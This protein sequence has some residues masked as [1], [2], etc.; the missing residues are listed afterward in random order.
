MLRSR[1]MAILRSE[2][3]LPF[4]TNLPKDVSIN[5]LHWSVDGDADNDANW[6]AIANLVQAFWNDEVGGVA[7][8]E[9][10]SSIIKRDTDACFIKFYD[11]EADPQVLL[12]QR[13]F[14]LAAT[15]VA[16]TNYPNEVAICLSLTCT[17]ATIVPVRRRR[18][19]MYV[20]PVNVG[21]EG[22]RTV[23]G[24]EVPAVATGVRGVFAGACEAMATQTDSDFVAW[25]VWSTVNEALYVIT[26]GFVDNDF[27]T[28]R[29]RQYPSTART[30]WGTVF[31]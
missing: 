16:E 2:V 10:L 1:L 3:H 24:E 18:G 15:P 23:G 22:S 11:A 5:A 29:R 7:P 8:G 27:D 19:R 30:T 26:G 28:Q 4:T 25:G 31:P 6:D 17:P 21:V 9:Y 20:G 13:N 14:T 12:G